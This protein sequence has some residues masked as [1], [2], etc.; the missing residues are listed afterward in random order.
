MVLTTVVM[1]TVAF[2]VGLH[3]PKDE[4]THKRVRIL[5][6]SGIRTLESKVFSIENQE[7]LNFF[8]SVL[9]SP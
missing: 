8:I 1:W 7:L 2:L 5:V 3:N 6:L 9:G 4:E